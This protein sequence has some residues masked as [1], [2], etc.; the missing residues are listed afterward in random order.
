MHL[1][2]VTC[3]LKPTHGWARYSLDL[4]TALH[5]AGIRLTVAASSSSPTDFP[6]PVYPILPEAVPAPRFLPPRLGLAIP[7][8]WAALRG[9]DLIHTLIEPFS[10]LGAVVAGHRPHLISAHGTYAALP[11][12]AHPISRPVYARTYRRAANIICTSRYT[13]G[14]LL[15]SVPQARSTVIP[16]AVDA[17]DFAMRVQA[18]QPFEKTGA[19][20]LT[21][22]AVKPRKGVLALIRA[23]SAVHQR[24]PESHCVV[25]GS[26]SDTVY[27]DTLRSEIARL[28]LENH[29]TLTGRVSDDDLMRWYRTAD[30][31]A[32]PALNDGPRFEGFGLVYLEASAAGLPVI[33]TRDC[34]AQEA[35][36][37]RQTGLL[38]SQTGVVDELTAALGQLLD[39]PTLSIQLGEN[40]RAHAATQTWER[41]AQAFIAAY[42]QALRS[43]RA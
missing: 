8:V 41:A 37:D 9:A 12:L 4:L 36:I 5:R 34:G 32:L 28:D 24:H 30:V 2:I 13:Q 16:N 6:F 42:E 35:I 40:G 20:I 21:V 7:R 25:V 23:F 26:L 38:V 3:E 43:R 31:F 11:T 14:V 33:G 22:G 18:A 1:G 15:K 19:V 17:A 10:H 39:S 27:A 29:V